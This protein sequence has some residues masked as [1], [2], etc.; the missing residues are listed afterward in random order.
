M[1]EPLTIIYLS[2]LILQIAYTVAM[3]AAVA[4][5]ITFVMVATEEEEEEDD[6]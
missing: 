4:L 3:V 6:G 5:A 1:F 2:P